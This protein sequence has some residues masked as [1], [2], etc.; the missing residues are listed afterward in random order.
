[1]RDFEL[2]GRSPVFAT[3]GMA[4][5]SHP[6]STE[7]AVHVLRRGG[8]AMDAAIAACAVQ[9]VVEPGSTGVGGDCFALYA[10]A[11]RAE[12]LAFNGSGGAP[13]A[14][15]PAWY[16]AQGITAI[17]RQSPHAVTVPG[18]V[19][20]WTRLHA[21]HGRLDFGEL[22]QPAIRHA[23]D[24]YPVA[25]R[26]R[27]DWAKQESLL[28]DDPNCR[29][30]FLPHGV[31]PAV[32]SLHAQPALAA[33]LER[34]A[35]RGREGFY[36]G[37]VAE[38]IVDYLR[39]LGG[40]HTPEDFAGTAGEYI[41]PIHSDF[42]GYTVWECPPNGQ[43]IVALLILNI[44]KEVPLD[45]HV[46]SPA[47]IHLE[48]EA[49]RLAYAQRDAFVADP[50]QADVPVAALLSDAHSRMLLARID[51]RQA[52]QPGPTRLPPA[53]EDTV[54]IATVDS[55]GNAASFINSLFHP[56]GSGLLAP[57]SGVLLHCR[58][59][60][61]ELDAEHPNAIAPGKRPMHTIIPG[62]LG[63][64]GRIRM[65]FGVMGG[66]YQALG[67]AHFLTRL[68]DY[69]CDLQEAMD[70]PRF[71]PLAGGRQVEIE[72]AIPRETLQA[73]ERMGHQPVAPQH[74]IGGA[75]AIWIDHEH[76]VLVGASDPRKDG[77]ALG[78]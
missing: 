59:I 36:Q 72:R 7:A 8:N 52:G 53:H 4:A 61:F 58:G 74:P 20:A 49:T 44:L 51:P 68:L 62:M 21:D 18:A 60:S 13:A 41:D 67:H 2:P 39:S 27:R 45:K 12:P 17:D 65:P 50:S 15:T 34:I 6:L 64:G 56:Y 38:D 5:T 40:L 54:Y 3:G 71:F 73:L 16:A 25:P 42:R 63:D 76:G 14:A 26:T 9:C 22:L 70:L 48:I 46:L 28:A 37:P 10:P 33:T 55:E 69:G 1:M 78:Y 19:D 57:G 35:D 32:G 23:R 11:G 43:G 29:A 24:G 66:H 75:Q 31:V 30:V 77:C 47:R